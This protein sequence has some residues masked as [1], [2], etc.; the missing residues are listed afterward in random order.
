MSAQVVVG[1][2][3]ADGVVLDAP[4]P[5]LSPSLWDRFTNWASDNKAVVYTAG[6]IVLVVTGAG[7]AYYVSQPRKPVSDI[8]RDIA[9][10]EERRKSKK[11]RRKAKKQAED[12]KKEEIKP[13]GNHPR[14]CAT[15]AGYIT[16]T[17]Q[18]G[19]QSKRT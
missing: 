16:H 4:L 7:V 5:S 14:Q 18:Q 8:E 12:V 10:A 13:E 1:P 2:A 6:A 19:L 11:D 15:V 3:A 17:V 9:A